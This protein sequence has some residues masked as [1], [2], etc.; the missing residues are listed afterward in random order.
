MLGDAA[1]QRGVKSYA[2]EFSIKQP[3][4]NIENVLSYF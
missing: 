3:L 4:F 2:A 1:H